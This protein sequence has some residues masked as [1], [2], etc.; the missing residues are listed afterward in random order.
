VNLKKDFL[1]SILNFILEFFLKLL[2]IFKRLSV[3]EDRA[4]SLDPIIA[5]GIEVALSVS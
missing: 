2:V 5:Y 1:R 4:C 3:Y